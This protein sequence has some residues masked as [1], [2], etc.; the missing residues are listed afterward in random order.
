MHV[1]FPARRQ[2]ENHAHTRGE[3]PGSAW[4]QQG[5]WLGAPPRTTAPPPADGSA[6][7]HSF[8]AA[9]RPARERTASGLSNERL[10]RPRGNVQAEP[11]HGVE[12]G[13]A[14]VHEADVRQRDGALARRRLLAVARGAVDG[15][16][17]VDEG[18]ERG[19]RGLAAGGIPRESCVQS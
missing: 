19:G 18:E 10:D 1:L 14:R 5:S 4:P 16:A 11:V 3:N 13:P 9:P 7:S 15:R 2:R 17:A 8:Q 12:P 6:T